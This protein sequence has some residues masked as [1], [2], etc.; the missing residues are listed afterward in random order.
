MPKS[1]PIWGFPDNTSVATYAT[2]SAFPASV[3]LIDQL[4]SDTDE[5]LIGYSVSSGQINLSNI[6]GSAV[7]VTLR[8]TGALSA[9]PPVSG[10]EV[11]ANS[12]LMLNGPIYWDGGMSG[13]AGQADA[14]RIQVFRK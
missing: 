5:T 13:S 4:L 6:S 12:V 10:A 9:A 1:A 8:S 11:P 3:P 2:G 7:T 14:V